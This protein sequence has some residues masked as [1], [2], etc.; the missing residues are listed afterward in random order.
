MQQD[1]QEPSQASTE[2]DNQAF[3]VVQPAVPVKGQGQS[4]L[5]KVGR[6]KSYLFV[7]GLLVIIMVIGLIV[8]LTHHKGTTPPASSSSGNT[9]NNAVVT[10]GN[11]AK[12]AI[13]SS[14][15]IP[16]VIQVAPGTLVTW[17][18][19]DTSS[20][21][22]ASDPYPQ[23]NNLAGF[24]SPTALSQNDSYSFTFERTGTFTYHDDLNPFKLT[25]T[26]IVK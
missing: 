23:D 5:A 18:N 15:F 7:L 16:A 19:N 14:G 25:G 26:V 24:K 22:V 8:G 1:N 11:V 4:I 17:T 2:T 6:H 13:T 21:Q 20:H 12:V 10:N 9:A 3:G